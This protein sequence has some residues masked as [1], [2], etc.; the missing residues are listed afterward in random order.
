[1]ATI[2]QDACNTD[3]D[4]SSVLGCLL[5]DKT[6]AAPMLPEV[7][8]AELISTTIWY[9]WWERCQVTHGEPIRQPT[10]T[11]QFISALV[12]NYTR[13]KKK[14]YQGIIRRG[15]VKPKEG[16]LKLNVDASFDSDR[17]TGTTGAIIRDAHG[18]FV[19]GRNCVL[20]F[21]EACALRDG[22]SLAEAMGCDRLIVHSYCSEAI[23][24]MKNGGNTY[25]PG[26]AIF[27]DCITF[28]RQFVDVIFEHCPREANMAADKLTSR[29]VGL[30]P[31]VWKDDL[32][33]F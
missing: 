2:I 29:A 5:L 22:M 27:E 10:R 30:L 13:A 28:C 24:V 9:V 8:H 33:I 32:L 7:T 23:E 31:T 18:F 3:R 26:A 12:I 4:G 25:G 6:A 1:M 14:E 17:G 15:W 11:A 16:Y 21:A 19:A 20:N